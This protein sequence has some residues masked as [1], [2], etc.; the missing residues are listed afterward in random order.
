MDLCFRNRQIN[1]LM[2]ITFF[3]P[4]PSSLPREQWI[5]FP[6]KCALCVNNQ[7]APTTTEHETLYWFFPLDSF[8][9]L[10]LFQPL[11]LS[12]GLWMRYAFSVEKKIIIERSIFWMNWFVSRQG[13]IHEMMNGPG[14]MRFIIFVRIQAL[15][16]SRTLSPL[17]LISRESFAFSLTRHFW[18]Y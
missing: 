17:L 8:L 10:S 15:C 14:F 11:A 13:T 5:I 4:I 3:S 9:S 2:E 6:L 1:Q 18:I 16:L 12:A 7:S